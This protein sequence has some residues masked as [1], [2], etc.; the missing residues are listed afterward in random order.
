MPTMDSAPERRRPERRRPRPSRTVSALLA[1]TVV[2]NEGAAASHINRFPTTEAT[3]ATAD[4]WRRPI[5]PPSGLYRQVKCVINL[6]GGAQ[7][8]SVTRTGIDHHFSPP[9]PPPPLHQ[10][11]DERTTWQ[12][13]Q[14]PP[15]QA[16]QP[17]RVLVAAQSAYKRNGGSSPPPP[18]PPPP[19]PLPEAGKKDHVARPP[20]PPPSPLQEPREELRDATTRGIEPY[21]PPPPPIP[22]TPTTIVS[23]GTTM[24]PKYPSDWNRNDCNDYRPPQDEPMGKWNDKRENVGDRPNRKNDGMS[25]SPSDPRRKM[26]PQREEEPREVFE[27]GRNHLEEVDL[28]VDENEISKRSTHTRRRTTFLG[29]LF[30]RNKSEQSRKSDAGANKAEDKKRLEDSPFDSGEL[31]YVQK[32]QLDERQGEQHWDQYETQDRR[33][34]FFSHNPFPDES[35]PPPPPPP[36]PN[37]NYFNTLQDQSVDTRT[38]LA[39]Y[40]R[41]ISSMY[42]AT[43]EDPDQIDGSES[44]GEGISNSDENAADDRVET[45]DTTRKSER[46]TYASQISGV[47]VDI[48]RDLVR[49]ELRKIVAGGPVI[50]HVNSNEPE[51]TKQLAGDD[52]PEVD[53]TF[54]SDYVDDDILS[55]LEGISENCDDGYFGDKDE[56][57][58]GQH[59]DLGGEA[60]ERGIKFHQ[61]PPCTLHDGD[62]FP[63]EPENEEDSIYEYEFEYETYDDADYSK[64]KPKNVGDTDRMEA[65]VE[66]RV[67]LKVAQKEAELQARYLADKER[68]IERV[69]AEEGE[70]MAKK[71]EIER[72]E[73]EQIAREKTTK[74]ERIKQKR[75]T[76]KRLK[77]ERAKFQQ[78]LAA[79]DKEMELQRSKVVN[80]RRKPKCT[81]LTK[82]SPEQIAQMSEEELDRIIGPKD[83]V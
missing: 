25:A 27:Q 31:P 82:Y 11:M 77:K 66:E 76:A 37:Q 32:R 39:D 54:E 78:A 15:V 19:P 24:R 38:S 69:R 34:V 49:E 46:K 20:L 5:R 21:P 62:I 57:W 7:D 9:P 4:A 28:H 53:S 55:A 74:A 44:D 75:I 67:R 2:G 17:K 26:E 22:P 12:P 40:T 16:A 52:S 72:A 63:D 33:S 45:E 36:L 3:T 43:A 64:S 65:E 14:V 30:G 81:F 73:A 59:Y 18:P 42:F 23:T 47:D 58:V 13:L 50:S 1:S 51:T 41:K 61:Q 6:Q 70:K 35:L 56:A 79:K 8:S 71:I 60:R 68:A 83:K 29:G 48:L 80:T 10:R